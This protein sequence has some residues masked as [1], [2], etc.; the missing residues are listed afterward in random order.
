MEYSGA[1]LALVPLALLALELFWPVRSAFEASCSLLFVIRIFYHDQ[2]DIEVQLKYLGR[3]E[4][5]IMMM[6]EGRIVLLRYSWNTFI[7]STLTILSGIIWSPLGYEERVPIFVLF[8]HSHR[9]RNGVIL[10]C[11]NQSFF[12]SCHLVMQASRSIFSVQQL[13]QQ[14]KNLLKY[15]KKRDKNKFI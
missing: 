1:M 9:N 4:I 15:L 10:P 8:R 7:L 14:F 5:S 11:Y 6:A 12:Y 3:I 2:F 13:L